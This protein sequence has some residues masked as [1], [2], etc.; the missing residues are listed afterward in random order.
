MLII[1]TLIKLTDGLAPMHQRMPLN[2][3]DQEPTGHLGVQSPPSTRCESS[4]RD[5]SN[6]IYDETAVHRGYVQSSLT[7][8][9]H[10]F[11]A[12][13]H[14]GC[15]DTAT[16]LRLTAT[17]AFST[18]IWPHLHRNLTKQGQFRKGSDVVRP[19]GTRKIF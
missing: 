8:R 5:R 2:L 10:Y 4:R 9:D 1:I 7:I 16:R 14:Q 17:S 19:S 13:A 15:A 3:T 11:G 18:K 6:R 12:A